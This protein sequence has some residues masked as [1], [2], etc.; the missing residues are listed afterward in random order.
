MIYINEIDPY[1]AQWLQNLMD[2][3]ALPRGHIDTRS[4]EDVTPNDLAG[5]TQHHFFAGIGGWVYALDLAG[6]PRDRPVWTGSCPCQPFSSAG[7][8]AGFA[9]ERHLWPAWKHLI[10][11]RKPATVFGEQV[12]SKAADDWV[13]L[14]QA[15]VEGMGYSFGC[16]PF[17]SAS[18]GAP[19]IRDR[20]YWVGHSNNAGLEGHAGDGS[21]AGRERSSGSAAQTG[22]SGGMADDLLQQ[23]PD[24]QSRV[25]TEYQE[26][27]RLE[28]SAEASGLRGDIRL[29][30]GDSNGCNQA[31]K[32]EPA[33]RGNGTVGDG[34]TAAGEPTTGP[35]NGFWSDADW[36]LCRDGKWRPVEASPQPLADGLPESLG[37]VC[38]A[39][40][41][42]VE[43]EVASYAAHR[44]TSAAE[45]LRNLCEALDA[46]AQRGWTPGGLPDLH[47]AAFLLAFV[48]QLAAQWW[49]I[50]QGLP[51]SCSQAAGAGVRVLWDNEDLRALCNRL[52]DILERTANALKGP[53]EPLRTHSWHDLPG[54]AVALQES[55]GCASD[56][57][58][59]CRALLDA[60]PS[61]T[62]HPAILQARIAIAKATREAK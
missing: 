13:D 55:A 54:V 51:L 27:G 57:L 23:R 45:E 39:T 41:A 11:Q 2:A 59:A 42:E 52:A 44:K 7:K 28:G 47:S 37:R 35:I 49:R 62:T 38:A 32:R 3:D 9:D 1:C 4:I 10:A 33:P 16:V 34:S 5:Y 22:V 21:P 17:S 18:V 40:I 19:H 58:D 36:L 14:V 8:G 12:A 43:A 48:C 25:G 50:A 15:D 60:L 61:A 56:L 26:A 30:D 29:A 31:R 53:P 46:Q 20:N 6:W 24:G